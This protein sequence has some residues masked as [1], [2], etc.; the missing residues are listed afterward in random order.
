VRTFPSGSGRRN[1]SING[2]KV[3]LAHAVLPPAVLSNFFELA[4]AAAIALFGFQSGAA[5]ATVVGVL[6]EV[7]V[8]LS[9]S[10]GGPPAAGSSLVIDG[11]RL[12]K[13]LPARFSAA[14]DRSHA[15][16]CPFG[17][18][19]SNARTWGLTHL[20]CRSGCACRSSASTLRD[21]F[22]FG[23]LTARLR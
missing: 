2:V 8:M 22:S 19:Y 16:V 17:L 7:P 14:V 21:L 1:P 10:Q 20:C 4:V 9:S 13:Y 11:V 18:L 5:L 3:G 23:S 12:P 15:Y 6:V